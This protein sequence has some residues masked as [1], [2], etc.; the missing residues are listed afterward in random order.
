MNWPH[1]HL[2]LNHVPVLGTVFIFLLLVV[3]LLKRSAEIKKLALQGFVL[4]TIV[5]IPI[6]MTG[7]FAAET[8]AA[9]SGWDKSLVLKHEESADQATAAIFVLGLAALAGLI[10]SRKKRELP[11][12]VVYVTLVL[13]LVT[14]ALMVRT[15]QAG[16]L[17]N[18]PE[19]H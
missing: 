2:A 4:L 18:H 15:A 8:Q 16:G 1:V 11:R 14:I 17:I 3:G 7:D 12:W 5:T 19:L 6:K 10:M 9:K 13:S